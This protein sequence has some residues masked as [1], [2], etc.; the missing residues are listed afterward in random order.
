MCLQFIAID[1]PKLTITQLRQAVSTP[2]QLGEFLH[3]SNTVSE[4]E[5]TRRCS[6]LI[7]KSEDGLSYEFAHFSV[8]EFLEDHEALTQDIG[9]P[10]ITKYLVSRTGAYTCLAAQCLKFLQMKNFER[11]PQDT[12][13]YEEMSHIIERNQAYP[14][15]PYAAI[16]WLRFTAYVHSY[17]AV[18][19][20][21]SQSLF[22]PQKTPLFCSW[23]IQALVELLQVSSGGS[24]FFIP[25]R[26]IEIVKDPSFRPL[27]MA[28]AL[29]LP[30]VCTSILNQGTVVSVRFHRAR[31][32]DLAIVTI[33]GMPESG[34]GPDKQ[35]LVESI[36]RYPEF[37]KNTG[38]RNATIDCLIERGAKAS[39]H[40]LDARRLSIFSVSCILV[41]ELQDFNAVLKLLESGFIPSRTEIDIFVESVNQLLMR[42]KSPKTSLGANIESSSL[43]VLHFFRA[44]TPEG[45]GWSLQMSSTLWQ[46]AIALDF[47]YTQLDF[48]VD[49]R[50]T[51]STETLTNRTVAAVRNNELEVAKQC[52]AEGRINVK[53][54][55]DSEGNTLLHIAVQHAAL[56]VLELLLDM[57]CDPNR[58]NS[59]G[60]FPIQISAC[61]DFRPVFDIFGK[62]GISLFTWNSVGTNICH[63][64]AEDYRWMH[65]ALNI[66]YKIDPQAT[67]KALTDQNSL[68]QTPLSLLL[69]DASDLSRQKLFHL[70]DLC[71]RVPSFWESQ[72]S[73]FEDAAT[74]GSEEVVNG[75][76][77]A[78]AIPE[79][80]ECGR[81]T[82][83]HCLSNSASLDCVQV[84]LRYYEPARD[85]VYE[86]LLPVEQYIVSSSC[87][88][89][90]PNLSIVEALFPT[91]SVGVRYGET[92]PSWQRICHIKYHT[93]KSSQW[94]RDSFSDFGYTAWTNSFD[95]IISTYLKLGAMRAYEEQSQESGVLPLFSGLLKYTDSDYDQTKFLSVM[96]LR[97]VLDQTKW[98]A[99]AKNSDTT[100]NYFKLAITDANVEV[101][102]LLLERG[103]DIHQRTDGKGSAVEHAFESQRAIKLCAAR[104]GREFLQQLLDHSDNRK[105]RE[106]LPHGSR[107]SLLHRLATD[108][109]ATSILWLV[110]ALV[111]RGVDVNGTAQDNKTPVLVY[112]VSEA[113]YQ[114][115]D[116]LLDLGADPGLS[117]SGS[118]DAAQMAITDD[119]VDFLKKIL[120][121]TT[122]TLT[123]VDWKRKVLLNDRVNEDDIVIHEANALHWAVMNEAVGCLSFYLDEGLLTIEESVSAEG[124]SPLHINAHYGSVEMTKI[125]VDRGADV[126]AEDDTGKTPLHFA[127]HAES[128]P[129]VKLLVE[130]GAKEFRD[131]SG[132]TPRD[133]AF[134]MGHDDILE[135]LEWHDKHE[136]VELLDQILVRDPSKSDV[137]N[138]FRDAAERFIRSNDLHCCKELFAKYQEF[139]SPLSRAHGSTL[140]FLSINQS[141]LD[142]ATWLVNQGANVLKAG[143]AI[144]GMIELSMLEKVV[145]TRGLESLVPGFLDAY[146]SQGGN[147]LVDDDYPLH[148]A[149]WGGR[150]ESLKILLECL[151]ER[152]ETYRCVTLTPLSSSLILF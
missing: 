111:H 81:C 15:Y 152:M 139:D 90:A 8:Q 151:V 105:L 147:L 14:F 72:K 112:H 116:L 33:L 58:E 29:N 22:K 35:E 25:R 7:R 113:S 32:I 46:F 91:M 95:C 144:S 16:N 36:Y 74:W 34:I 31:P 61:G 48:I 70:L 40:E 62:R 63:C 78:G 149:L 102:Q 10:D 122:R 110:K 65:D 104:K 141:K 84:L 129:K 80:A 17:D 12:D 53:G 127:V 20:E 140:L 132:L 2:D 109:D 79:A 27:H 131:H 96:T 68:G 138:L 54:F 136:N 134:M 145:S 135:W 114:C 11:R 126:L 38:R 18:I 150:L 30:Q 137:G 77:R 26:A 55:S 118:C 100:I 37:L 107:L 121:H 41:V 64:W 101:L 88:W 119:N 66:L 99:S 6:S 117:V 67:A 13:T 43:K 9:K 49:S 47:S 133:Y 92:G 93:E 148:H 143:G 1:G 23:A 98:W 28:A 42:C 128:L 97:N 125:L 5:I 142:I 106:N 85:Y 39:N 120:E 82:P 19:L 94:Y 45:A 57:G 73:V 124:L 83:L 130:H 103:V 51:M 69:R 52:L 123:I 24:V 44:V 59:G 86:E 71:P 4:D 56:D 115:A 60:R 76:L 89:K 75:L 50:V 21:L 87:R 108:E 3:E 146:W